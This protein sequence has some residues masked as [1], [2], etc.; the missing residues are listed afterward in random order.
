MGAP[1]E[2]L[3]YRT[4]P[5]AGDPEGALVLLHGRAT[6]ENDLF[7]ILDVLDPERRHVGV[8]V[9]GPLSLPPGGRHWYA[10]PRV[11]YPD[12][13]TFLS[14]LQQ[15]SALLD[16]FP[17]T[18]GVDVSQTIIGGFSQGAVM[19]YSL[20]LA[21][22]RPS[23]AGILALSGF[24]PTVPGFELDLTS[25]RG[26]PVAIAHGSLDPVISV[27]FARQAR[28][29][30]EPAGLAV[31]YHESAMAHTIDPRLIPDLQ[32]WVATTASPPRPTTP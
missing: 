9:R 11:G 21:A 29:R 30:L 7:P 14:T 5:P 3:A 2:P 26:L 12:P 8:T 25:R 10:V 32:R 19:S 24:I 22:S 16:G 4:R 15:L 27:Q 20:G 6:D 1:T 18:L 17:H 28:D 23:P 13:A 31:S